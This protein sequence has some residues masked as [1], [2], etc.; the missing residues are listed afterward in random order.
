MDYLLNNV[1]SRG[2]Q[3]SPSDT[4]AFKERT[5]RDAFIDL[6]TELGHIASTAPDHERDAT[7]RQYDGFKKLFER[8]LEKEGPSFDWDQIQKLPE[9]A[10]KDYE[11]L[12][13]P[14]PDE[15]KNFL[16][17]LVVVK[18]NGG[19]GTSMGCHGPKSVITVRNGLTF[20]DLSV[21]Q[22]ENLNKIY[23]V[24]VPLVLMNSFNTDIDTQKIIKKYKGIDVEIHTFN[25][26]CYPRISKESLLPIAKH[27][28]VHDD[29]EAWYPPGHGDFYES[30]RN[31]GLLQLLKSQ[32]RQYCFIS[33]IDN[34]GATVDMR[35]LRLLLGPEKPAE[36]EFL[37]EVTDKTRADVKGGTLIQYENKLRLLELAQ[38][39][40]EHIEDFKSVKTFKY[41]NTNNL[42]I[43]IDAIDRVLKENSLNLEIIVNNKTFDNGLNIIQLETA[44]GAAMKTF[45]GSCGIHVPRSR[46][47]PVKKTSDLFLVMSNL[48]I[49]RNGSLS[50]SP[51]R[52]FPTTP[53]VKLG[54]NH[55]SKVKQFLN[56]FPT[57]PDILELDHLTVSGDVTF[58]K[59]VTLK[60]TVIIIA[61]QGERIDLPSGTI[62]ENKIVSGNLRILDH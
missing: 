3:R 24:S 16:R 1:Y 2:H 50:M 42:W 40:R 48:Y 5:K 58:G 53:L 43:K 25:Q 37:M 29:I 22:I 60:G 46:F 13:D 61:N 62:L 26:S 7:A 57:I 8:F 30:F 21:Q 39:P 31:S 20:L 56:R 28:R 32:G 10:I 34:L 9:D 51:Q 41:F 4:Q 33:N 18:L 19:L 59:K 44:V 17:K 14:T 45:N 6:E 27:H 11:H 38:V 47:L 52:M 35:I 23:G 36:I 15:I 55:F 54:D 49:L 12:P